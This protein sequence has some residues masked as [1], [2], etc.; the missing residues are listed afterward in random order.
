MNSWFLLLF[1]PL[2]IIFKWFYGF[3][4]IINKETRTDI[5]VS[6]FCFHKAYCPLQGMP[7]LNDLLSVLLFYFFRQ[8]QK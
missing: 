8:F 2:L 4:T 1:Y 3:L 5:A 7:F 6:H